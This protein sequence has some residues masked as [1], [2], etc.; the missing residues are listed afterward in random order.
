MDGS[1]QHYH[2]HNSSTN[3]GTAMMILESRISY[4]HRPTGAMSVPNKGWGW[5][6]RWLDAIAEGGMTVDAGDASKDTD[7]IQRRQWTIRKKLLK[8]SPHLVRLLARIVSSTGIE[9]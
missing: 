1:P 9:V 6:E 8:S 4:A 2:Q 7:G 3:F 5:N